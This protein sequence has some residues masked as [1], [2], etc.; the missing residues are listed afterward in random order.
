MAHLGVRPRFVLSVSIA[1]FAEQQDILVANILAVEARSQ[2]TDR[3][4]LFQIRT[5]GNALESLTSQQEVGE[6]TSRRMRLT[7]TDRQEDVDEEIS[8]DPE[9]SSNG[10]SQR[11]ISM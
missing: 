2:S 11:D 5:C 8:S 6:T 10:Y 3:I 9:T 4:A 7:S 1:I